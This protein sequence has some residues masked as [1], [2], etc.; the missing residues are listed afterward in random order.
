MESLY[1]YIYIYGVFVLSI[2]NDTLIG[3]CKIVLIEAFVDSEI[4]ISPFVYSLGYATYQW[5][6]WVK[7][8]DKDSLFG[9]LESFI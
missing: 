9:R 7:Q 1:I 3:S 2:R 4:L 8:F 6:G 5:K